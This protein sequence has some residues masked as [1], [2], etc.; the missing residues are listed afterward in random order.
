MCET[1]PF[2]AVKTNIFGTQN[3]IEVCLENNIKQMIMVSTD[4][5]VDPLNTMGATKLLAEKLVLNANLYKGDK[6]CVFSVLRCPNLWASRGSCVETWKDQISRK[7]PI[8]I[9]DWSAKRFVIE[10][11]D[12]IN[13]LP[14][15]TNQGIYIPKAKELTIREMVDKTMGGRCVGDSESVVIGLSKGERQVERLFSTGE[16]VVDCDSYWFVPM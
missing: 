13:L 5:A 6:L 12:L 1:H 15:I 4:K 14:M 8:T 7:K 11:S 3:V 16:A 10:I 2:E 9:T